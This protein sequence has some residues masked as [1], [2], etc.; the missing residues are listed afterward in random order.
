M[1]WRRMG[2]WK[3]TSTILNLGARWRW[4]VIF[5]GLPLYPR[6]QLPLPF[7]WVGPKAGLDDSE[8]WKPPCPYRESN[9]DT[10][11]VQSIA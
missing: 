11:V 6:E 9:T 8:K 7:G 5:V 1:P 4:V 3:Y 10:S 2:E